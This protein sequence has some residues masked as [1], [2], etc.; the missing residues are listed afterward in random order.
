M[1]GKLDHLIHEHNLKYV[2]VV[3]SP[4]EAQA[5]GLEL[6]HDDSHAYGGDK[7]FGLLIHGTQ[8]AGSAMGKAKEALRKRDIIGYRRSD[9]TYTNQP[10]KIYKSKTKLKQVA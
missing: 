7:S 4:E 5:L 9:K 6:D 2:K 10:Y 1:G 3:A 8:K